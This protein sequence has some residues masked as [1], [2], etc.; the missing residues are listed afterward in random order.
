[1]EDEQKKSPGVY[2]LR[3]YEVSPDKREIF[4]NRFRNHALRI[5]KR[6]GFEIIALWESSS[7][8]NFE[9]VYLLR[10]PDGATM[11]RQWKAFLSDE[12]WI[13]IKRQIVQE[14][15]EPVIRVTSRLLNDVEY[16]PAFN[17]G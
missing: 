14:V 8:M 6:H 17:P 2:Q 12:E 9:F 16:S 1:M 3:I 13:G 4:H 15:G 10:W 11:D 7:V 5:M